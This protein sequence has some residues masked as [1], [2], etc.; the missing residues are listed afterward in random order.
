[1]TIKTSAAVCALLVLGVLTGCTRDVPEA[2]ATPTPTPVLP[3]PVELSF[4]EAVPGPLAIGLMVPPVEGEGSEYRPLAEGAGVAV[5]RFALTG[6]TIRL[7]VALD[8]G[9]VAGAL[10]SMNS[11]VDARVA[12]VVMAASGEH[13]SEALAAAAAA[14]VPVVM[15]YAQPPAATDGVW[16]LAPTA[17]QTVA[18]LDVALKDRGASKPILVSDDILVTALAPGQIAPAA[19]V[20]PADPTA[21]AERILSGVHD[22]TADSAIIDAPPEQQAAVVV[23]LQTA[24][25]DLQIPILLTPQALTPAFSQALIRGGAANSHLISVGPDDDDPASLARGRQADAAAAYYAAVRLG[26]N[27]PGCRNIYNDDSCARTAP[28]ADI[29]SHDALVALVRAAERAHSTTPGAVRQALSGLAL[30]VADGLAGPPLDFASPAA[31]PDAAVV[32][33]HSSTTDP[34]VRPAPSG[35]RLYWFSGAS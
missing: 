24:L 35:G 3:Q 33:L 29:A 1:M 19:V 8:D 14:G 21:A 30:T 34:G 10:A 16:S 7:V 25:G 26:A 2:P 27:D 31:L 4:S 22:L 6:T 28:Y 9:T 17:A 5:Q 32:P 15:P 20:S 12:G 18:A 13:T 11:L 23:A